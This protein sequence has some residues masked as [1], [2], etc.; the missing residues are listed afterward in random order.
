MAALWNLLLRGQSIQQKDSRIT[1]SKQDG[2]QDSDD[3]GL[4]AAEVDERFDYLCYSCRN[5]TVEGALE[6]LTEQRSS[7]TLPHWESRETCL[8]CKITSKY[9]EG[10]DPIYKHSDQNGQVVG[11]LIG[12][13]SKVGDV[14]LSAAEGTDRRLLTVQYNT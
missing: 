5:M 1:K 8:L 7:Q 13:S 12:W 4:S 2:L 6:Q 3:P 14:V 9:M 10:F 11:S